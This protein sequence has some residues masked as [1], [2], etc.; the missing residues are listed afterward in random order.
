MAKRTGM[1][2]LEA[3]A[4]QRKIEIA[5]EA[6][7]EAGLIAEADYQRELY[8]DWLPYTAPQAKEEYWEVMFGSE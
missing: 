5:L 6:E 7:S 8:N 2:L 1:T 4:E 3:C